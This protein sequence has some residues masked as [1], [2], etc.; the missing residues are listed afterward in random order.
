MMRIFKHFSFNLFLVFLFVNIASGQS[1]GNITGTVTGQKGQPVEFATVAFLALP[2]SNLVSGTITGETGHFALAVSNVSAGLIQVSCVGFTSALRQVSLE[3]EEIVDI[4]LHPRS[5]ALNEVKAVRERIKAKSKDGATTY[6]VN[7]NMKKASASGI[8][9]VKFVPGIQVDMMQNVMVE[10]S[11]NVIIMVDGIERSPDFLGQLDSELIDKIEIDHQ[12][13]AQYRSNITAVVNVLTKRKNSKG[14]SGHILGEIPLSS[15]EIYSFPSAGILYSTEKVNVFGSYRGEFSYF[16]IE[17]KNTKRVF[18]EPEMVLDSHGALHQENWSHKVMGGLDWFPDS[19]N[20]VNVYAFV[21]PYSNEQDGQ[22]TAILQ[23]DNNTG[24]ENVFAK[25]D[26]DENLAF[27][28]SVFYKHLFDSHNRAL[29]VEANYYQYDGS[30][31]T[32]YSSNYEVLSGYSD[33]FEKAFVGRLNYHSDLGSRWGLA[34]GLENRYRQLGESG[35][36]TSD[37][38][39]NILSLFSTFSFNADRF[40]GQAGFRTEYSNAEAP[41][42]E[43]D[44]QVSLFPFVSL[45]FKPADKHQVKLSYRRSVRRPHIFQLNPALL[46]TDVFTQQQGNPSLEPGFNQELA[47]EYSLLAGNQFFSVGPFY[48]KSTDVVANLTTMPNP[49]EFFVKPYNLGDITRLGVRF[50]AALTPFK[51]LSFNPYFRA[52]HLETHPGQLAKS[53]QITSEEK[54]AAE[55]GFGLSLRMMNGFSFSASGMQR[56]DVHHIQSSSFED[57]LYFVSLEKSFFENLSVGVTSAVPFAE[58]VTYQGHSLKGDGFI[59]N[60]TD[61]ILTSKFPL[62]FKIKYSFSSGLKKERIQNSDEFENKRVRKGF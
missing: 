31:G 60:S 61:N 1:K 42:E 39:E 46:Q 24:F 8:D 11:E 26:L 32:Q 44:D 36:S 51:R 21:N 16:D 17:A 29:V 55:W 10:G 13:G 49:G 5:Y 41:Q 48:S 50:K 25:D 20:Q 47:L 40:N 45:S 14:I 9:I 43:V 22:V 58:E 23:S 15:G 59:E 4:T 33:P 34:A 53:H 35:S 18:G 54:W 57:F 27:G 2:D 37:Y 6:F 62:W 38:Q 28:G 3:D 12:P 52:F 56:A 19:A 30:R 7:S